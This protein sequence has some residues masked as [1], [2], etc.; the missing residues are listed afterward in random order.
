VEKE[1]RGKRRRKR[2]KKRGFR[3][4]YWRGKG[5]KALE[6]Q[7]VRTGEGIPTEER[8]YKGTKLQK[9]R[10]DEGEVWGKEPRVCGE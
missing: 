7:I 9:N 8:G 5:T 3:K 1:G 4:N 6:D 2:I 10:R